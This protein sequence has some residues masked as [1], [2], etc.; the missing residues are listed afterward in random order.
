MHYF[1][2]NIGDYASHTRHLSLLEDLAYRRLLDAYYLSEKPFQG[3]PAD[4][5]KEIGMTSQFETNAYKL[6]S[7][8]ID[9]INEKANQ[10]QKEIH[11]HVDDHQKHAEKIANELMPLSVSIATICNELEELIPTHYYRLPKY[12]DMLFLK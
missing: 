7:Q 1:N 8:K 3:S 6:I 11:V 10:L 12:Y 5:A 2:F 4:I 9:E